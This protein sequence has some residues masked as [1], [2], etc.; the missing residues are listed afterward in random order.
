MSVNR[1]TA[2]AEPDGSGGG[3]STRSLACSTRGLDM[4]PGSWTALVV[5][6][7]KISRDVAERRQHLRCRP[8]DSWLG[9]HRIRAGAQSQLVEL[10]IGTGPREFDGR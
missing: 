2:L 5:V 6:R 10:H 8:P 3:T 1:V 4:L 7:W 9:V